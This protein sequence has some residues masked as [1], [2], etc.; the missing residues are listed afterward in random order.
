MCRDAVPLRRGTCSGHV[1]RVE[2]GTTFGKKIHSFGAVRRNVM[3]ALSVAGLVAGGARWGCAA[4]RSRCAGGCRKPCPP[5][6]L[7]APPLRNVIA[8]I[9]NAMLVG[10]CVDQNAN[11][12]IN[13]VRVD[14]INVRLISMAGA[15]GSDQLS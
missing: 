9:D 6:R 5:H 12:I 10:T 1:V 14:L 8:G 3:V 7:R 4:L 2:L 15:G 13:S 11:W